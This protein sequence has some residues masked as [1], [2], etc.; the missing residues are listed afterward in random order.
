MKGAEVSFAYVVY[1]VP[2][3]KDLFPVIYAS[4]DSEDIAEAV[5]SKTYGCF[6]A[7]VPHICCDKIVVA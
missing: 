6:V 3:N 2:Q 5:A 7:K 1:Y 4:F